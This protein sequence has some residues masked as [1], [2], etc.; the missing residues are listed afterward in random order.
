[1]NHHRQ[2]SAFHEDTPMSV[3]LSLRNA[4][5][6]TDHVARCADR[7]APAFVALSDRSGIGDLIEV[8]PELPWALHS[9]A[10]R[11]PRPA[12]RAR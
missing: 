5:L 12:V 7:K 10:L 4:V 1:M 9:R 6:E 2:A 11:T 3:T 8:H